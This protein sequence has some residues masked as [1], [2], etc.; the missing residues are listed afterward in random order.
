MV[1]GPEQVKRLE[2]VARH[3]VAHRNVEG[4]HRDTLPLGK[5]NTPTFAGAFLSDGQSF[6][7]NRSATRRAISPDASSGNGN[8]ELTLISPRT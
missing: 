5:T 8:T 1:D 6:D 7:R 4:H 3:Q 2:S